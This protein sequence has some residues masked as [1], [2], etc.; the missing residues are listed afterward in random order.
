MSNEKK[1]LFYCQH[2]LGL[3]HLTRSFSLAAGL[4]ESYEV[5]FL[6]GGPIPEGIAVPESIHVQHLEPLGMRENGELVQRQGVTSVSKT[7]SHRRKAILEA[8]LALQPEVFFVELFPFGR[9]KFID[10]LLPVLELCRSMNGTA[11]L[12]VSSLRDILVTNRRDQSIHDARASF[13]ANTYFDAILVHSDASFAAM[14]ETFCPTVPLTVPVHYTGFV[15]NDHSSAQ[16]EVIENPGIVVSVGGGRVGTR[17][18]RSA[19]LAQRILW[20]KLHMPM[21][22]IS[23]PFLPEDA[24]RSLQKMVARVEGMSLLRSVPD[25]LAVLKRADLSVSQC[26]Y[27]T[28]MDL[29]RANVPAIVVPYAQG[30]ENEQLKRAVK[31]E[32]LGLARLIE[33]D[34]LSGA[35]LSEC[36]Q[37]HLQSHPRKVALNLRGV[38]NTVNTVTAMYAAKRN[39]SVRPRTVHRGHG[40]T[41][42]LDPV[43]EVLDHAPQP[44]TVFF[45]DDDAGWEDVQLLRLLETFG[46]AGLPLDLAVIPKALGSTLQKQLT[47]LLQ[48]GE[49]RVG[50][51]QH[52]YAHLNHETTGRKCEFGASRSY[53]DQYEDI[54]RGRV[55]LEHQFG[56]FLDPLFTPPWNR[57]TPVTAQVLL[58][59]EMPALSRDRTATP[60]NL[61]GLAELPIRIDWF[62]HQ[63]GRRLNLEE[64]GRYIA[65]SLFSTSPIGFMFHHAIMRDEDFRRT[66]E[67][68]TVLSRHPAVSFVNMRELCL[69]GEFLAI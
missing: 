4:A 49:I 15:C 60:F 18:L 44:M 64:F 53:A 46:T 14:E 12:V 68:L 51:H 2:S 8:F 25:L 52:G 48:S 23:G 43:R 1:L 37:Q 54:R 45:R 40:N 5:H 39:V 35:L 58:D 13:L 20:D 67:L 27:N 61:D 59:L 9:K 34:L 65:L 21:T 28:T 63:K 41:S 33:P 10:E 55:T 62:A 3:G 50:V 47:D 6:N 30:R 22:L 42:W 38:E 26:G 32:E 16:Q 56:S 36:I 11:P 69:Q 19:V 66:R 17:L 7:K 31:L 24:F 29:L 57:C